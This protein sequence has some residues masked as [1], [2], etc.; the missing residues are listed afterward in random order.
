MRP[1]PAAPV[2]LTVTPPA[3]ETA[4]LS[5]QVEPTGGDVAISPD[6]RRIVFATHRAGAE[7]SPQMYVRALDRLEA[8]PLHGL[9][10]FPRNLFMSPDGNWVGFFAEPDVLRKVPVAGSP[11]LTICGIT[12]G[13]RGASWGD[14]D[15][16]VFAT[17]DVTTGLLRVS[18][19]GGTAEVL[20]KPDAQKGELDH[21]WPEVLPG[22][23]A[24]LFTIVP[25]TGGIENAQI[26][27]LDLKTHEQKVLV[28]GGSHPRYV[29][30]GHIVYGVAGTL[31]AVA[32]DLGRLEVRSDPVHVLQGVVTK[33]S[34]GAA[35]FSVAQNGSLVYLAG[36]GWGSVAARTLVWVDRLGREESIK[37]PPRAYSEARI[38][39]D[40]TRVA[41][42]AF[43]QEEDVWIWDLRRQTLTRFTFDPALENFPLW[44]PDGRRVV[45]S[46]ARAGAPNM[47]WQAADGTGP[48]ERL[49][50]SANGQFPTSFSPDGTRLVFM[51]DSESTSLDIGILPLEGDRRVAPL[52]KTSFHEALAEVS[53]DG[54]WLAY[55][56]GESGQVEVYVRPF[57]A[58]DAGKW[59]VSTGGGGQ[60]LWARNGRELFYLAG[61]G[62]VM[63][64]PLQP[65]ATFAVGR[66]QVVFEG[67]YVVFTIASSLASAPGVS[68]GGRVYDVSA[69]GQR[70]LMIKEGETDQTAAAPEIVVVQN[71]LEELKRLVPNR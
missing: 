68:S 1:S 33:P 24:V 19:G 48:V 28:R 13:P 10:D 36:D 49:A 59:Q 69:D 70:F 35:S 5:P 14:A 11:A 31:R 16:I 34:S 12:G 42:T 65:G 64:A 52:V 47:F 60:P 29:P 55:E 54:R 26:A 53:P 61:P 56:S 40:G 50:E 44:T 37:A 15:E 41:V 30:T 39:P 25:T 9:G 17:N 57:P 63:A 51:E 18:A 3:G 23:K 32:F 46:S 58:V 2:R 7:F 20:T 43:D 38:S 62:R 6:G 67:P 4:G 21:Y 66:P 22:G 8:Q 71:W 27:V 45:F